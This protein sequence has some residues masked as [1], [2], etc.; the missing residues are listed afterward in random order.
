MDSRFGMFI[1]WGL[2]A[3][4]ARGEWI[5][6]NERLSN[7]EYQPYFDRFNPI[8]F[9]PDKWARL[10]KEAGMKYVVMTAKHHDGFCLFDSKYTDY[11]STNT[12]FARDIIKEYVEAFRKQGLKVGFYY[13]LLDWHHDD[14]PKYNDPYHPMRGNEE[15][16]DEI[17]NFDSYLDYMHKQ[18]EELVTNY[19]KIDIMWFDFAY[20]G[21]MGEDW[22]ATNLVDMVRH[23]Q[24]HIIIDNRLEGSGEGFGSLV[25]EQISYFAGDFVCPEQVLP[26]NGIRN[27]KGQ[28]IPWELCLT[29]NGHWGYNANDMDFKSPKVLIRKLVECV[30][31]GG[32][33]LLNIGPDAR[34][35]I[36]KESENILKQIGQWMQVNS[37]S[38]YGC[39][40]SDF[41]K[42]E[43][44]YF[45]QKANTLYAHV[46]DTPIGPLA[47][48]EL[49][50]DQIEYIDKLDD[51]SQMNISKSWAN[52][53]SKATYV[54]ISQDLLTRN[55]NNDIDTVIRIHLKD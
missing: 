23:H 26:Y 17:V 4:P 14:Y 46:F 38:I 45:T 7:E 12:P 44:G 50:Q 13:S 55:T 10:A 35:N 24:P 37:E 28:L 31:K 52:E 9:D 53:Y 29:M 3:I 15:F 32:N 25:S 1:H 51:Y 47:F 6:N 54:E 42:P 39:K 22:K 8:D 27:T 11:K 20:E 21:K 41:K 19:G 30:S 49:S 43:W 18:V 16:K 40:I 36:P 5:R 2:Y 34:G 48:D 33:L